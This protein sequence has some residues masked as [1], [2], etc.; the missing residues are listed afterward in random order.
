[1]TQEY[2]GTKQVTA[3]PEPKDGKE[4]FAVK[5]EGGYQSWSPAEVFSTAYL[6]IG[7]VVGKPPHVQRM[8]GEKAQLD[9]RI[10]K[11]DAFLC[12]ASAVKMS[13]KQIG[14]MEDQ[15]FTMREYSQ[16]LRARLVDAEK[17]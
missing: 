6:P 15:L 3:W 1:M 16:I 17:P 4:G 11:L 7:H 9:D 12:S 10:Q 14:L 2:V 8:I 13:K 5:Y